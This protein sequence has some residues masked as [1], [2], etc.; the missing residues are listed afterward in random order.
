MKYLSSKLRAS[1]VIT[2][3]ATFCL[4]N[5]QVFASGF[6]IPELSIA[7]LGTAN[8]LVANT[9]EVGA[10][11]YNPAGMAFHNDQQVTAG[12]VNINLDLRATPTGGTNT[13]ST[14]ESS[15]LVPNLYYMSRLNERWTWGVALNAPFGLETKWPKDTFPGFTGALDGA[16][17][18]L[19]K[20]EMLNLNPNIAYQIDKNSSFSFGVDYYDV[21]K[22][23][24]NTQSSVISGSGH[25]YGWNIS[26]IQ[27]AGDLQFGFSYHD[28]IK[29]PLK[30][31]LGTTPVA[32][33]VEFP[34]MAQ[35]GVVYQATQRLALEFDV[36]KTDW[37]SYDNIQIRSAASNATL[38][39]STSNWEDSTAYRLSGIY[40]LTD[41]TKLFFGYSKD[42]TP[43]TGP[44]RFSARLPDADRQLYSVGVQHAFGVWTLEAA[45]MYINIDSKTVNSSTSF[46]TYG[47]DANGTVL[48]NG[49]YDTK[50]N[51]F[52]LGINYAFR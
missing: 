23:N 26:F 38:A 46:G 14:G 32:T 19:S 9:T 34:A 35:F 17:P 44:F 29:V 51:L 13:K 48:Y 6:R 43:Q 40:K 20:I 2:G 37:S 50:I 18:A 8:A 49:V 25:K 10:L 5:G 21:R 33:E 4:L 52:G 3:I 36:D 1:T 27:K 28:A 45:Y 7:G 24:L 42:N 22:V 30:G 12:L 11:A 31:T 15:F 41:K 39:T 16:E 47:T